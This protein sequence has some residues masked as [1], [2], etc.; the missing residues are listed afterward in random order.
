MTPKNIKQLQQQSRKLRARRVDRNT[1]VV[2]SNSNPQANHV[3]MVH[4]EKDGTVHTRCTC[5]WAIHNGVACS[6]VLAALEYMASQKGR[7]LSF[8]LSHEDA[9]RQK[10]RTFY[11]S[12][13]GKAEGVWITSRSA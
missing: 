11:L 13:A 10:H 5:P 6:H 7:K 2:E 3:V 9:E 1:Y 12:G 4:F 8:W